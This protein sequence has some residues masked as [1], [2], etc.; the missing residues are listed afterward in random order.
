MDG[1][2]FLGTSLVI[3]LL[4]PSA[5]KKSKLFAFGLVDAGMAVLLLGLTL[6]GSLGQQGWSIEVV[7]DLALLFCVICFYSATARI[8]NETYGHSIL[9]LR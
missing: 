1:Y 3:L 4:I 8:T 2:W 5:L 6:T 9:P 7:G